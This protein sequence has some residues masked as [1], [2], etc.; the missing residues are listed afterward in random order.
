MKA[1]TVAVL[2]REARARA[3]LSQ[4]QL[5]ERADTASSVVARIELGETS[6]TFQTLDRLITAAG[7]HLTVELIAPTPV[8]PVVAAYKRDIDRSLLRENLRKSPDERVK[9]LAALA[10]LAQE[11]RRSGRTARRGR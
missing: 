4:R 5:A 7:F 3:A 6:P 11:A 9:S 2:L 1:T 10:R 8:D